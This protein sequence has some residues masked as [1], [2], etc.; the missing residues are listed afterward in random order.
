MD[1]YFL[2]HAKKLMFHNE[3]EFPE[4]LSNFKKIQL[5]NLKNGYT[6]SKAN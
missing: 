4:K 6:K 1:K 3:L 2:E 5:K